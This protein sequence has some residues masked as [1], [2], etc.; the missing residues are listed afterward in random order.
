MKQH[1]QAGYNQWSGPC[2]PP[3]SGKV[4][5]MKK[6]TKLPESPFRAG[7]QTETDDLL[8]RSILNGSSSALEALIKKHQHYIY[9][10]AHKMVLSPFDA[11]DITQEVLIVLITRLHQFKGKSEF[12]TWLYRIV[13]NHVLKKKKSWLETYI[14]DFDNYGDQLAGIADTHLSEVEQRELSEY[15]EEAKLSCMSGMLLCLPRKQRMVYVLGEILGAD[16]QLGA[17]FL[18]ISPDNFR[19]QLSRARKD[20][21]AFMNGQCGL[22]NPLNPCRCYRKTR[23]FIQAGWVDQ[24]TMKFNTSYRSRIAEITRP[25]TKALDD[26]V[27]DRA[28]SVFGD[29][30]FQ[31]KD[32]LRRLLENK[33]FVAKLHGLFEMN[34]PL[35]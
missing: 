32:H 24:K 17:S 5:H 19:Q 31:E 22:I 15:I 6:K 10:L 11:E 12:R 4:Q 18:N 25:K 27:D 34:Y 20:M 23:G 8:I 26:L 29:L 1:L 16:H 13:M 33:T 3:N 2:L 30:P 35:K 7:Y 21:Y 9:N 28:L 14:T